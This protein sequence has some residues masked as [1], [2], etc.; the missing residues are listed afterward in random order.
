MS[1]IEKSE[2]LFEK[3]CSLIPKGVNSPVRAFG[4][5][6][7]TPIFMERGEGTYI[8]DVD[9]NKYVD[10]CQSW[11]ASI[12]GHAHPVV[13]EA[14]KKQAEK[15]T[16]FGIPTEVEVQLADI[17][18]SNFKKID[19]VR[20]VSSGTEAVMSAVRLARGFTGKDSVLKFE[21]GY[22]GHV[23]Y[24]LVEAGSGLAT[25]G[26]PASA[27]VTEGNAQNTYNIPLDDTDKLD[28]LFEK[29]GNDIACILVEGIPANNGLLIQSREFM[30]HLQQKAH[31]HNALLVVD[32]V[33]TGFRVGKGGATEMYCID[34]DIV[35]FGKVIGGG[36]PVGAF[37]AKR[38]IMEK[39]A[40]LGPVYQAGTLSGNPLAMSSGIA[41]LSYLIEYDSWKYLEE[42]GKFWEDNIR[43]IITKNGYPMNIARKGSIFWF[44]FAEGDLPT[45]GK[46]IT[47]ESIKL[48]AKFFHAMLEQG[49]YFAPSGYEVGFLTISHTKEI[50]EVTLDA[51]EK[52][53][54]K[55]M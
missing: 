26:L 34:P 30:H 2:K 22:H 5:V 20:F 35:T 52:G 25:L 39:I 47:P 40:P 12:M 45:Q 46:Q 23:D 55:I 49:F 1:K 9:G 24:L 37:G 13:V 14:V 17:V 31:K 32:E 21:G 8:Y 44:S 43:E 28:Q 7:G 6:G 53:L 38:E 54:Q 29:H 51:M 48:Y 15:G 10:Y 36:L 11:G 18:V 50:L 33:I 42:I 19:M 16:S 41:V 27:G 4:Q 3:A